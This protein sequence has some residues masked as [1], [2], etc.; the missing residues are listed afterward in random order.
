VQVLGTDRYQAIMTGGLFGQ[1]YSAAVSALK[2]KKVDYNQVI[3]YTAEI[4]EELPP[5]QIARSFHQSI[6]VKI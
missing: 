3:S 1:E 5:M 4:A 6:F 2:F